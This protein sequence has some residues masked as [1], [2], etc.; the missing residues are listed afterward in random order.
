MINLRQPGLD[1]I[2]SIIQL[3]DALTREDAGQYAEAFNL[4]WVVHEGEAAYIRL[5]NDERHVISLAESD[6]TAV[7]YLSG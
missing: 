1:D 6:G 3:A 4:D 5:I 7:G 2:A